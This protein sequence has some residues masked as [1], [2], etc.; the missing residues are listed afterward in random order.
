MT[1]DR[2]P[3]GQD[4][5]IAARGAELGLTISRYMQAGAFL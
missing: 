5:W 1:C 3:F 4:L 2:P